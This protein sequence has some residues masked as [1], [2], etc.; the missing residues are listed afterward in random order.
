MP[1]ASVPV[2]LNPVLKVWVYELVP[3]VRMISVNRCPGNELLILMLTD[4]VGVRVKTLFN[5]ASH[6]VGLAAVKAVAVEPES[7]FPT[8]VSLIVVRAVLVVGGNAVLAILL[9]FRLSLIRV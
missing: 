7:T 6:T 4:P 2:V 9:R 1:V 3:E 8:I 5:E